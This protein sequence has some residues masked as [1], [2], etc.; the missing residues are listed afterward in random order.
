V[1]GAAPGYPAA[2]ARRV[3]IAMQWWRNPDRLAPD[4]WL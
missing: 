1:K 2:A 3:P 4:W